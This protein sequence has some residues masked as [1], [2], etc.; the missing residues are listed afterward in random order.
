MASLSDLMR[1]APSIDWGV[2]TT[3]MEYKKLKDL[4]PNKEY[5]I[6]GVYINS[7]SRFGDQAVIIS[8]SA[9]EAFQVGINATDTKNIKA[10]LE[11]PE[12]VDSIK[13]GTQF[14]KVRSFEAKKY[15]N[16]GYAVDVI[17]HK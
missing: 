2:D 12:I 15:D 10:A 3:N 9:E 16:T 13:A 5:P 1:Q 14:F 6:T 4:D 7:K 17:E 8:V 11:I